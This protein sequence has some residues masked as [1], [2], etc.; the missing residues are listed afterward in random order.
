MRRRTTHSFVLLDD[1]SRAHRGVAGDRVLDGERVPAC[2][3]PIFAILEH[4]AETDGAWVAE[5][6]LFLPG[7]GRGR[8][9]GD[10]LCGRQSGAGG[11]GGTSRRF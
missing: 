9:P 6:I 10:R 4:G 11:H 7:G 3:R 8:R 5:S 1:Q 2:A